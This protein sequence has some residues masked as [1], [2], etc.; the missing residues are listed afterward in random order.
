[1]AMAID[2]RSS[3][4]RAAI[5]LHWLIALAVIGQFLGIQYAE[6]LSREDPAMA[7]VYMIHKSTGLTILALT[8]IRLFIRLRRGFIPLPQ[9]MAGWE[10]VLARGTHVAFYA[11]LLLMPLS[12]WIFGI[13]AD[14]GLDWYGIFPVPALPA[15]GLADAAHQFHELGAWALVILFVLHVLGALKHQFLDRDDVLA[16]MLPAARRR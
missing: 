2:R 11:L 4:S 8:L 1:M 16:R 6:G 15:G 3:Y 7:T 9:H 5:T 13:S 14:R 12:G 10:I